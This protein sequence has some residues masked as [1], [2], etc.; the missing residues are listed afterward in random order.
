ML[1]IVDVEAWKHIKH[2]EMEMEAYHYNV[3]AYQA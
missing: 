2:N 3:E 1:D